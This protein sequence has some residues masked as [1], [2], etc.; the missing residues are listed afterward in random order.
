MKANAGVIV[1]IT[2]KIQMLTIVHA[3]CCRDCSDSGVGGHEFL[4]FNVAVD[5]LRTSLHIEFVL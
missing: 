5:V 3:R 1:A 2:K 4:L